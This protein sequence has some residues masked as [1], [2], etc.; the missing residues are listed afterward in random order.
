MSARLPPLLSLDLRAPHQHLIRVRLR[1]QPRHHRLEL[2][3]PG[4]TP[5][6]YLIRDYVR[7]LEGLEVWQG[8]R[9]RDSQRLAP[10]TWLLR[11]SSLDPLEVRYAIQASDL[12]V[13]TCHLNSDH[14]FLALAGVALEIEG[15]RWRPHELE[16]RLPPGWE[17][18]L[19]L[20]RVGEDR[21]RAE[22][23]DALIDSPVEAGPHPV[24]DFQ[25]AGVDHRWVSWGGDPPAE[26]PAWL[27]DVER[28]C[29]A[30]CRLLGEERPPGDPF[31]FVLH[32]LEEGY[33][34]L[35]HNHAAVLQFSRG[36]L[37]SPEG[38]R[39]LLGLVA[40]EYLH[41]WNVRRLRPVELTPVDYG[42]PVPVP[43]LWFAEGVTSY[44]D[45]LLPGSCGL[46]GEADTLAA[47]SEDLSRY[48]LCPGRAVQ[49]LRD[50]SLEAW[51]KLYRQDAYSSG[52]Q[53]SYYLKG[54]VL[55]LVLDLHLR[56]RGSA[57]SLVARELWR[58]FGRWEAGY[59]EDDLLAIFTEQAEDL[60]TLLPQWLRRTEDPDMKS[61]LADVGLELR[62]DYASRPAAGWQLDPSSEAG[63]RLKGVARRGA[64]ENAG[65]EVGDELLALNRQRVRRPAEVDA[66]L[67]RAG[68]DP[69]GLP[70][71]VLFA[72]QGLV[73]ETTLIPDPPAIERWRLLP[74][75]QASPAALERR[76]QW[77]ELVP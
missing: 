76:R 53:V 46:C 59:R 62:A 17:A 55:A 54:A 34:G 8:A 4:W 64:A 30:C 65:L 3:L 44:Y 42:L 22:T 24:H 5:G 13:R 11:L 60:S 70:F 45:L 28:V 47:L 43:T 23:F 68:A 52:S 9:Q 32:L 40:H 10:A 58:R 37:A 36:R 39:K 66:L 18:F 71:Q 38:R 19:P 69:S 72:R 63:V 73:R 14:A 25:V 7:T 77:L 41:Q 29:L 16:L 31:L 20:P 48:L 27:T 6:S 15:E 56:R 21:W 2:R 74:L 35:E 49:S 50:S 67:G 57:L 12:T 26:D 61:Y 33:G 1:F 51:V 75:P